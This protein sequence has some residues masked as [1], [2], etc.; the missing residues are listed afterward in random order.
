MA[1]ADDKKEWQK[2]NAKPKQLGKTEKYFSTRHTTKDTGAADKQQGVAEGDS[3]EPKGRI[4]S[5]GTRSHSTYGSRDGHDMTGPESTAKATTPKKVIKKGTDVL[6]RAFKDAEQ[7]KRTV[8]ENATGGATGAAS[9]AVVSGALG[10]KGGFSR[11]DLNKKL[12]GY[13]NRL[14]NVKKATKVKV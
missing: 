11:A 10:E 3:Q 5:D 1:E 14:T 7:D 2:Q 9:V 12:G 4:K 8:K 6:D 13:S